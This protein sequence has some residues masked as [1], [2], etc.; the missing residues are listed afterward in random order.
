MSL[1]V[2]FGVWEGGGEGRVVWIDEGLGF[3]VDG[4][5]N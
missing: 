3:E 2:R 1:L 4:E 5:V